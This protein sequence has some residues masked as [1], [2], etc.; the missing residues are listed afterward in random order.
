MSTSSPLAE[1]LGRR[2]LSLSLGLPMLCTPLFDIYAFLISGKAKRRGS[3]D[4]HHSTSLTPIADTSAASPLWEDQTHILPS[5][6]RCLT[7][8]LFILR[9]VAPFRERHLLCVLDRVQSSSGSSASAPSR[10]SFKKDRKA[11][12]SRKR[13]LRLHA[14]QPARVASSA[15]SS[16]ERFSSFISRHLNQRR[17]TIEL[18]HHF[19]LSV[20][21]GRSDLAYLLMS[22]MDPVR[23]ARKTPAAMSVAFV[24]AMATQM[25]D[26]CLLS[27]GKGFP[28]N[29]NLPVQTLH[30]LVK[31]PSKNQV[32][33]TAQNS[34][35]DNADAD[36][37]LQ[38]LTIGAPSFLHVAISL[39]LEQTVMLML[40]LGGSISSTWLGLTPLMAAVA[41]HGR[42]SARI[43]HVLLDLGADPAAGVPYSVYRLLVLMGGAGRAGGAAGKGAA[44]GETRKGTRRASE[45]DRGITRPAASTRSAFVLAPTAAAPAPI[46]FAPSAEAAQQ[47]AQSLSTWRE[48]QKRL[49]GALGRRLVTA[50]DLAVACNNRAIISLLLSRLTREQVAAAPFSLLARQQPPVMAAL[51][52]AGADVLQ[53]G[54]AGITP[55]HVAARRGDSVAV[56]LL[57]RYGAPA[58]ERAG[59]VGNTPLHD[60]VANRKGH[61]ARLLV[62]RGANVDHPNVLGQTPRQLGAALGIPHAELNDMLDT[63]AA[64]AAEAAAVTAEV[65]A[66]VAAAKELIAARRA[67]SLS[68]PSPLSP[69]SA[70][71]T[72][73]DEGTSATVLPFKRVSSLNDLKNAP[74]L[75][76]GRFALNK[77]RAS[78]DAALVGGSPQAAS[79]AQTTSMTAGAVRGR[80]SPGVP[81]TVPEEN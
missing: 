20:R 60:A 54:Q 1:T 21:D 6:R 33:G 50:L 79:A 61:V 16:F 71:S 24:T 64:S 78:V 42:G 53:T 41:A 72:D 46:A 26:L 19:K 75:G 51:L 73:D 17:S 43:A 8:P 80:T 23:A 4:S 3:T 74:M 11:Y 40:K 25:E 27:L 37:S 70:D 14:M 44:A 67:P 38:L 9:D 58:S 66:L 77:R 81:A 76:S 45:G 28:N 18:V 62:A 47:T 15:S 59:P 32:D 34:H 30:Y 22:R 13:L 65:A 57:L 48:S 10:S 36:P 69:L 63:P 56:A 49:S 55:V 29:V 39:G 52:E 7:L 35:A 2:R 5:G 12:V 31:K 68:S